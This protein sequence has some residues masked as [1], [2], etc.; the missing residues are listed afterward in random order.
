MLM[1]Q[2]ECPGARVDVYPSLAM[3][4][5][6]PRFKMLV[7]G[8]VPPAPTAQKYQFDHFIA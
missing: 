4:S 2:K 7:D 8:L 6:A 5:E 3:Y 1:G